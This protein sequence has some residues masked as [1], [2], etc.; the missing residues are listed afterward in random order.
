[1]EKVLDVYERPFDPK[2]PVVCFDE[3]PCQLLGDVLMPLP[4]KPGKVEKQDYHYERHGTCVVLMAVEPLSG[5]RI[6]WVA[7]RKT[8]EDYA[9]FM[10][11]LS[12]AYSNA[13]KIVLVQDNLNTHNPS[14]FY[15]TMTPEEAFALSE[16]FEMIYTPKKAS[17]LNMAEIELSA[18]S[19]QCL[20]RRIA[21]MKTLRSEVE[22][23]TKKRN[24]QKIK[25]TWNFTKNQA[26]DKFKRHYTN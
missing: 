16:R 7:K 12:A 9:R 17:W 22:T 24:Q 6:V 2:R 14:S 8:K 19:K 18:L 10:K 5:R 20:D 23:W 3:R 15:E 13:D 11:K 25:I 1:M 4:M 21:E 26:R